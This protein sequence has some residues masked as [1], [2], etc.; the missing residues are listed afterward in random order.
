MVLG[1]PA[2]PAN[3][4]TQATPQQKQGG[5]PQAAAAYTNSIGMEFTLIPTGTLPHI[6]HTFTRHHAISK[7]FYLGT[8][9]VTQAQWEAVRNRKSA[10]SGVRLYRAGA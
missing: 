1:E 2:A 4:P 6:S 9:E 7:P 3:A 10:L 8:Y 5:K